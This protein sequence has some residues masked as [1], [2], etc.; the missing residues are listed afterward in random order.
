MVLKL[1]LEFLTSSE[2]S[3]VKKWTEGT[4]SQQVTAISMVISKLVYN[5]QFLPSRAKKATRI[6]PEMGTMKLLV[7][8]RP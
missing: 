1:Y 2:E 4:Q 8:P 6:Q 5:P 3:G 7:Y